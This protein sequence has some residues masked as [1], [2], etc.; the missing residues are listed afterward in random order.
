MLQ[1]STP[2]SELELQAASFDLSHDELSHAAKK[3]ARAVQQKVALWNAHGASPA[4]I[5][6]DV[7]QLARRHSIELPSKPGIASTLNRLCDASWWRR[8]LRKRLRAV[9][10]QA[11]R[12]G[13]VH[14]HASPYVSD[15]A[16][17]RAKLEHRRTTELLAS[18]DAIN[19]TTGEVL[20]L[21]VLIKSSLANPSNRRKA[22]MARIKGIEEHAKSKGHEA[23][24]LTITCPS[25]M[26]ARPTSGTRSAPYDGR[27]PRQAQTYLH[28]LWRL[29]MRK[30][31]HDGIAL[32][33]VRVSEPHQD[34][35]PH[36]HVLTFCAPEHS[37]QLIETLRTYALRDTPNEPGAAERRFVVKRIDPTK[38]SAVGYVAKY[39]AKSID[40]EGVDTDDETD[41]A[42]SDAS[43]RVVTWARLWAI[44]QFQF[45]GVPAITPTR[46]LY[47]LDE[48]A[49]ASEGLQAAHEASKTN[50]YGA[51]LTACEAYGLRF[52]VNYSERPS[53]RYADEVTKRI[54][55]LTAQA[56]DLAGALQIITRSEEWRIEV[57]GSAEADNTTALALPWTRFTNCA[58]IDFIE[59][60]GTVDPE[61]QTEAEGP[62]GAGRPR[63]PHR[64]RRP[65]TPTPRAQTGGATC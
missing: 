18:M 8:A 62:G 42:G 9:E 6:R 31:Q 20:P 40:G 60:F 53:T 30:L 2:S 37:D 34:A 52:G 48:P 14:R 22:M 38:G 44:R 61:G 57:R 13:V 17:R 41:A 49:F 35:C 50:N 28:K 45:F 64:H 55:G 10:H 24:F 32:T 16:M 23:L 5:H 43:M 47:R 15:R 19:Q 3:A 39:I 29:A 56:C 1:A 11:I 25:R 7:R 54:E 36:W 46:E 51:W 58:P 12:D 26:H 33:G 65:P 27:S 21:E 59:V 4:A 63:R